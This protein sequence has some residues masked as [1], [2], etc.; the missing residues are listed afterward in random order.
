M[1]NTFIAILTA[2][3]LSSS[4]L[5]FA[6]ESQPMDESTNPNTNVDTKTQKL[7]Q[8]PNRDESQE[9]TST[10]GDR[11]SNVDPSADEMSSP[12]GTSDT[13]KLRQKPAN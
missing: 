1:R 13:E 6:A 3:F 7:N 2:A 11:K 12:A 4:P 8:K 9:D 5:L 10:Y